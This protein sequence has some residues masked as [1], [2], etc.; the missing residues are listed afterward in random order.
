MTSQ[1]NINYL[2][3]IMNNPFR[4]S[5]L[6]A[7]LE[8]LQQVEQQEVEV[9]TPVDGADSSQADIS[10]TDV[11]SQDAVAAL[12]EQVETLNDEQYEG[13]VQVISKN[14][15]EVQDDLEEIVSTA[16][17]LEELADLAFFAARSGGATKLLNGTL[18]LAV[19]HQCARIGLPNPIAALEAEVSD[20]TDVKEVSKSIGERAKAAAQTAYNAIIAFFKKIKEWA[21]NFIKALIEM[22]NPIKEQA[23]ELNKQL[24]SIKPGAEITN[25]SFIKALGL[26]QAD[27]QADFENYAKFA[28]ASYAMFTSSGF[29]DAIEEF[30]TA[31]NV[32]E[33]RDSMGKFLGVLGSKVLTVAGVT[34]SSSRFERV[35]HSPKLIGGSQITYSYDPNLESGDSTMQED[36]TV[37][38][39]RS[40][41]TMDSVETVSPAKI[42]VPDQQ[43]ARVMLQTIARWPDDVKRV[44]D[45]VSKISD[46]VKNSVN[47]DNNSIDVSENHA[48]IE[49]NIVIR[50]FMATA[51][52]LIMVLVPMLARQNVQVSRKYI[53]YIKQSL[54]ASAGPV[55]TS[56]SRAVATV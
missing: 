6:R 17:A 52:Q 38:L 31:Q 30:A 34:K 53:S 35:M 41:V 26:T 39:H 18:A 20:V 4:N 47:K 24:G 45:A 48:V 49:R 19:E 44:A 11:A 1:T 5:I 9:T 8:E 32:N 23:A 12:Q 16:S 40:K 7:A 56:D 27:A 43:K 33:A 37:G 3:A 29:L 10:A 15:E 25:E 54:Q 22:F 2:R 42:A 13:D 28:S 46:K 55:K 50:N 21:T 51:N 14:S 36:S